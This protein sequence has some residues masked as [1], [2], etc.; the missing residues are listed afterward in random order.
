VKLLPSSGRG[1]L[2]RFALAAAIVVAFT[3]TTTAVA[4]LL[5]FK[6][7]AHLLSATPA[8]RHAQVT[9][10]DPGGPQTILILG[11]DHRAGE[12]QSAANSD[13]IILVRLDP[14]SSTINVIS[15]PRDLQ[16][17]IPGGPYVSKI[18]AAYSLGGPNLVVKT[19]K[20]NVFPE[21]QV[22]HI[23]DINFKGFRDLV[24]AIG[25][26]Y[27][28]VDRRYFHVT[29]PGAA[30][31]SSINV[32]AGYQKL[33]GDDALAYVR[34]RH[35]DTDIVRSARQQDFIRQ[36][37]DQ[38]GQAS[39]IS[40]R[41][42]LLK[43]FGKNTQTDADLHTT[44]G[45]INLFNLV[46]FSDV[47]AIREIH[48]P[49]ILEPCTNAACY[50]TA[51]PG[52]EAEA[53]RRFMAVVPAGST[54]SGAS[55]SARGGSSAAP[56]ARGTRAPS[57]PAA[58]LIGDVPDGRAQAAALSGAGIPVYFPRQIASGSQYEGPM[59]GEYP[60]RYSIGHYPSYR[61]V[62]ARDALLGQYYGVEGT[63][64]SDAPILAAPYEVR[65]VAGR[66]LELH[67]DGRKLRLV[68]WRTPSAVYWVSNTLSLD[69][70]NA[71]MLGIAASLARG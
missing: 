66:R 28:D 37:K 52:A 33:C 21:L 68:A 58:G 31:W 56:A 4:G 62:I 30:N 23:V 5:E 64:W 3:A 71:Q 59:A 7:A 54:A 32:P 27:T 19:I 24:D 36:A 9:V 47:H 70:T 13:T 6:Q 14:S 25:C 1:A 11:S 29:G 44:D 60:R 67:W 10:P 65:I 20:E 15:I 16:V 26:V 35:T 57:G 38:Y 40:N 49:A 2:W 69:L 22:N 48:F 41:D 53:Y 39:L 51:D 50:V 43:I 34:Y 42:L 45:L 18:N 8:I 12:P 61:I 55:A 46:A 17:H 63:A